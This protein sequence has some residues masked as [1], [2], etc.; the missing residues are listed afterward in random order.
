MKKHLLRLVLSG[1]EGV[2]IVWSDV[3]PEAEKAYIFD[4]IS[5]QVHFIGE[6]SVCD[7]DTYRVIEGNPSAFKEASIA[8]K[9]PTTIQVKPIV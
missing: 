1:V 6:V 4:G 2:K 9:N 3:V 5:D 8:L 7:K